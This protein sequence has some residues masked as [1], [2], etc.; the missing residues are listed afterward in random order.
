MTTFV[1]VVV[2]LV[3]NIII[4]YKLSVN[5]HQLETIGNSS[6]ST[7]ERDAQL[8]R[9]LITI[10]FVFIALRYVCSYGSCLLS[11]DPHIKIA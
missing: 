1:V 7:Q 10:I 11:K 6:L 8:T 2:L 3:L 4:V 5:R 9:L